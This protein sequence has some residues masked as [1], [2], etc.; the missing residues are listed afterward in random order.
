ML[1][2]KKKY[3]KLNRYGTYQ[4][5]YVNNFIVFKK[6]LRELILQIDYFITFIYKNTLFTERENNQMSNSEVKAVLMR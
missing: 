6:L 4:N 5:Y 1:K 2:F 3:I